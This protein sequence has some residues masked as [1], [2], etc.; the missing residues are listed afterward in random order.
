MRECS[1][2]LYV[3][4]YQAVQQGLASGDA[5]IVRR[6]SSQLAGRSGVANLVTMLAV[7]EAKRG[8]PQHGKVDVCAGVLCDRKCTPQASRHGVQGR[9]RSADD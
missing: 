6:I 3:A 7:I 9:S 8:D 2:E 4:V 1:Y 5:D